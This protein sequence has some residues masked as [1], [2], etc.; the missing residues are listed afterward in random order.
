MRGSELDRDAQEHS[1]RLDKIKDSIDPEIKRKR[2]EI[3]KLA[4]ESIR[5]QQESGSLTEEAKQ[6]LELWE[7]EKV[8]K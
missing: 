1:K 6:L 3:R 2:E 5:K 7:K 4:E 8:N